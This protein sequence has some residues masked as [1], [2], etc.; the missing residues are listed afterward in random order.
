MPLDLSRI[1]ALIFDIDGTLRDTDDQMTHRLARWLRLFAGLFPNRDPFPIARRLIIATES[2]GALLLRLPDRL[3]FDEK[4]AKLGDTLIRLRIIKPE[5]IFSLIPGVFEMLQ[6]LHP[7]Y[8]MSI[9]SARGVQNTL[10]FLETYNL[11]Q[12]FVCVVTAQTCKHTK[13]YP[14]PIL[15]A[16]EQMDLPPECCLMIGDTAV[17]MRAGKAAG[18]QTVGVLCGF[19]DEK[20]LHEAGADLILP[21]TTALPEILSTSHLI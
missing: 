2:P 9:V 8:P 11:S 18:A 10:A 3:G 20:E 1:R 13:P 14:D 4:L 16:A 21:G 19:G 5:K 17:D 12:F 15:W 6:T 7:L